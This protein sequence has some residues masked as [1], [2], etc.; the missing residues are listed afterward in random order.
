MKYAIIADIH[1]NLNALQAVLDDIKAQKCTHIA[2][3]GDIVGYHHQP[4]ERMDIIR[5][6][7]IPVSKEI[8]MNIVAPTYLWMASTHEPQSSSNGLANN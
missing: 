5:G 4:K 8:T 7:K 2:C 6:L 3:L 1:A